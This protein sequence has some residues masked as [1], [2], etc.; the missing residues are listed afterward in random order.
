MSGWTAVLLAGSRPG[1]DP[2][3]AEFGLDLKPLVPIAGEAMLLRPLRALLRSPQIE[4]VILLSQQPE[5]L[6]GVIPGD[7]RVDV[8]RS[9]ATI[10][11]S[12]LAICA[13]PQ[14]PWPLLVT[15]ADHALL[16]PAMV[17]EFIDGAKGADV[18]VAMVE[19]RP[20]LARFPDAQRTW[21]AFA[22]GRYS[23]ANLFAFCSPKAQRAIQQWRSV[24]ADRKKGLRVLAALGPALFLGAVLK[25]RTIHQ[26]AT[27]LGRKLDMSIRVVEMSDP[28]AAIDVDKM[29]DHRL[30]EAILQGRA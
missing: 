16:T 26:T 1:G 24:E 8:R 9:A 29:S 6:A 19:S 28:L 13:D 27:A 21:L 22:N 12:L 10:A 7:E 4:R 25:L 11:E 20:L 15:T 18:A 23:G 3:A 14:A 5:R 17:E 30:V 2:F